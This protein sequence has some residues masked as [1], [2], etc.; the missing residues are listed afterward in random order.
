MSPRHLWQVH[1]LIQWRAWGRCRIC[2][3]RVARRLFPPLARHTVVAVAC[4]GTEERE[5][6]GFSHYSVRDL[7]RWVAGRGE[8]LTRSPAT[9]PRSLAELVLNPHRVR[10]FLTRTDPLVEEKRAEILDLY[11]HPPQRCRILCLDETTHIQALERLHPMRPLRPGLVERQEFEYVRH[12][13][14]DLFAAFD[15]G[16]GEVFAPCYQRPTNLE[17]RPFLRALR[18]RDPDS[19][20]QLI[21][22]NAGYHKQQAVLD[23]CAAQRPKV[24][25]HGLP[26]HGSWLNQVEIGFSILSRKCLRRAS[27]RS[28]QDLRTLLH[29]F[30][31]IWNTHFAHPFEW[32]YTG[33]PLAV[34]PQHYELLAA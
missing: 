11:L 31:K 22:D 13:P 7:A 15:V 9:V 21:V 26:T 4:Q 34:A 20:W 5:V 30:I 6:G 28:T 32:T 1:K 8:F 14:G 18:A 23:W 2:P 10:D 29:R 25:L 19:R 27:V 17:F 33:K 3:G 24:T 12:G 16:T